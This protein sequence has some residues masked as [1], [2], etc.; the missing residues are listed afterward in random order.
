MLLKHG[1]DVNARNKDGLTP[2]DLALQFGFAKV[3][4]VLL[5]HGADPGEMPVSNSER[6][7]DPS[8]TPFSNPPISSHPSHIIPNIA[9][10]DP[11]ETP[12]QLEPLSEE[13]LTPERHHSTGFFTRRILRSLG[14]VAI[15]VALPFLLRSV[16]QMLAI[17]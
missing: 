6:T 13:I 8:P 17:G 7:P 12:S 15:A 9:D 16:T 5:E 10:P 11:P 3:R 1:A 14:I 2:C 4:R